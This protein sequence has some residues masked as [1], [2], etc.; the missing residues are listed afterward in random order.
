MDRK[1]HIMQIS[2]IY[3]L[4]AEDMDSR[5]LSL[6]TWRVIFNAKPDAW[7]RFTTDSAD[8]FDTESMREMQRAD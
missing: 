1:H 7:V 8:H 2:E 6:Y 4:Y 3:D 5:G